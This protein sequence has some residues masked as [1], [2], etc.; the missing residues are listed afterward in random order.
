MPLNQVVGGGTPEAYFSMKVSQ[1]KMGPQ[2]SGY[3]REMET[4]K[5]NAKH[6]TEQKN[7]PSR[8]ILRVN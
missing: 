1:K 2:H 3:Q 6:I 8:Y 4:K 7:T 5:L